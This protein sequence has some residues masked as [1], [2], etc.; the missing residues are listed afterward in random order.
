[1][2]SNGIESVVLNRLRLEKKRA[3][4]ELYNQCTE[5]QQEIFNRMYGSTDTIPEEKINWAIQQCER[6]IFKNNLEK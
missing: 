6:T 1:M 4:V 5:P 3:L 2:E